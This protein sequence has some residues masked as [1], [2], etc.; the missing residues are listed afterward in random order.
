MPITPN[1]LIING[2]R[3]LDI[4]LTV[5]AFFCAY[6]IKKYD[7]FLLQLLPESIWGLKH[8]PYYGT[9]VFMIII[10]WYIIFN[11]FGLYTSNRNQTYGLILWNTVKAVIV[12]F[13][14]LSLTM[15][16]FKIPHI[17]RI[18][19][20][21]FVLLNLTLLTISK[22]IIF[23]LV[24]SYRH[25][26]YNIRNVLILGKGE[27][28]KDIVNNIE[29]S[30]FSGYRILGC[31][32]EDE[33]RIGEEN[34]AGVDVIGT[35][36]DFKEVIST[37]VV[38]EIIFSKPLENI[39]NAGECIVRAEEIGINIRILPYWNIEKIGF[40]PSIS[41]I[42][43][44]DFLGM[45]TLTLTP[46]STKYGELFIKNVLDYILGT[47]FM[48]LCLP[49]FLI[50]GIAIKVSSNGPVL[51]RQV[52]SGY[53]GRQFTVYKF[54]TMISNAE[55]KQ[56]EI[57]SLN[58]ADGP[59]F[60]IK[61]DPRIIPYIGNFLRVMSLDELPQLINVLKGEMSLVGPRPPIPNEVEKY[62]IWQ[63]RRLS[64][65]PGMTCIWQITPNRNDV[66]FKEWMNMDLLYIDN[67]SLLLDIKI[68]LKTFWI[69]LRGSGR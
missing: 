49:L 45:P 48:I 23:R 6:W 24:T 36:D 17:S 27:G 51:F 53:N 26:G 2:H 32:G 7:L 25:K 31:L 40:K 58:E 16:I 3:L 43:I 9:I 66:S 39:K 69:I 18:M 33:D 50:F 29:S 57:V 37:Q 35:L 47:I 10:I 11:F 68:L 52:R 60:K 38:D 5:V 64:M 65:K 4:G 62:D 46:T 12:G 41:S 19:L 8:N 28:I 13:I 56:K 34:V 14:L 67:W 61:K 55:K 30:E 42:Q 21:M 20:A 59:V 54:R 1:H 15:Y 22:G 63:R 44:S